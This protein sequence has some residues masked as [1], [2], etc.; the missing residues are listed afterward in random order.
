MKKSPLRVVAA[1]CI[2]AAAFCFVAGMFVVVLTDKNATERDFIEYWAAAQQLIH[3]ANP[4]DPASVL[5]LE[6][7]VGLDDSEPRVTLSPP[8]ALF[9]VLPLGF[10]S[11]K[12]GLILWLLALMA[13]L[14]ASIWILWILHGRT[15]SRLHLFGYLFAPA[16]ACLMAGQLGIFL[17]LGVV[18][19]FYLHESRPYLAGAA[20]L[21]CALKPHLFLPFSMVLLLW[22]V[23]GKAYRILGGFLITLAFSCALTLC[24]NIHV[25]SQYS[26]MMNTMTIRHAFVPTLSVALRFLINRNAVWLQFLPAAAGSAWA[27]WYFWIRRTCWNWMDQGLLVLLVSVACAP[28]AWFSDEAVLLPAVLSGLYGAAD[29]R[30]SLLPIGLIAGVALIEVFAVTQMTSAFYLWTVPAWFACYLYGTWRQP[31]NPN[32]R[33]AVAVN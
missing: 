5:R 15:D 26:Q 20:L 14:S 3:G 8:V 27:L 22:L 16:L 1:C 11:P 24:V 32:S 4:Y 17:L 23:A 25:W 10:L 2:L 18:L 21:P 30:R 28:Y 9:L 29:S 31:A 7:A 33:H 12:D 13:S 6:R 19:F